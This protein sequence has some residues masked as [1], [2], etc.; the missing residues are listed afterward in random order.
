MGGN[1]LGYRLVVSQSANEGHGTDIG[2]PVHVA[3]ERDQHFAV[4]KSTAI[5]Q[6]K[7]KINSRIGEQHVISVGN[8]QVDA[9]AF[10]ASSDFMMVDGMI[11]IFGVHAAPPQRMFRQEQELESLLGLIGYDERSNFR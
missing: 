2:D 9:E 6:R 10:E 1:Q 11:T 3:Q 5:E 8:H 4:H 7:H